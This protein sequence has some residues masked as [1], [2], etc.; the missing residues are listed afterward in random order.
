M[1]Q[2]SKHLQGGASL[3]EVLVSLVLVA[4]TMLGLLGLQ[5]R[6]LGMQKDSFDRRNAA[7]LVNG[8]GDRVAGNF[9]GFIGGLY[10]TAL[11]PL[12]MDPSDDPPAT[13]TTCA[14]A[15]ACTINEVAARDWDW[16]TIDVRNRLP[17]GIATVAVGTDF[18]S[19]AVTVGWVDP[20]RTE[21][22]RDS[23]ETGAMQVDDACAAA[24]AGF[25]DTRYR[26]Y[27]S[28]VNP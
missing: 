27:T 3:I 15:A 5:L 22:L 23:A 25:T 20:Q 11:A 12:V 24:F 14:V 10:G 17:R 26:C 19:L 9:G 28:N 7:I 18:T 2:R 13:P 1:D 8:F 6:T 21:Q 16:F 4:V